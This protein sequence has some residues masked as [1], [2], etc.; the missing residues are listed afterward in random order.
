M[1]PTPLSSVLA[2]DLFLDRIGARLDTD[3]E[4]GSMLLAVAH[5]ADTPIPQAPSW[6]VG[7]GAT[8]A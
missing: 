8:A 1:K 5:R 3:D 4:L 2:D 7:S 6:A